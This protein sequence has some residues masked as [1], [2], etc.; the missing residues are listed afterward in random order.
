MMQPSYLKKGDTVAIVATA[1]K[2]SREEIQPAVT[3]L[4]S[5]G[6]SVELGENLFM[7]DHQYA[8]AD[9]QRIDDL[10][11][12]LNDPNI[13][14]I[15]IARGGYGT[16]RLI[17]SLNFDEFLKYP[18]WIAGYSDVTVMHNVV[19]NLNISTLHSTM[20]VNFHKDEEATKSMMQA[21]FGELKVIDV[22]AGKANRLGK[23]NAKVVGGNLSLMYS[24]SGTPYDINTAGTILFLEDLDEYLYH[25]DRMMM[26]LKLAGKL[27]NLSGLVIGGMT[28]MKDNAVPF[29][30][31]AEE[32]ILDAVKDYN[33]PVCFNFPAGHIA[34]NLALYLGREAELIVTNESVTLTYL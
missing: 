22:P 34:K 2:I 23:A 6:L 27:K 3:F 1:R 24:L 32:I 31:T 11:K 26:Q 10:Q 13:K 14:A 30:K 21:L 28:D 19:Y 17:E 8:G 20:P 12:A 15:F 7:T 29:G 25:I 18:K 5:Y 33:Y 16:V 4:E 9:T